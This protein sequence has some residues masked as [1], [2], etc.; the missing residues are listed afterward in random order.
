MA[1]LAQEEVVADQL[2]ECS[3]IC[4]LF[5]TYTSEA[6]EAR[7]ATHQVA[8]TAEVLLVAIEVMRAPA[9][10]PATSDLHKLYPAE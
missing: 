6:R 5:F 1:H 8:I 9:E 7:A 2:Q 3:T 10:V 4:L